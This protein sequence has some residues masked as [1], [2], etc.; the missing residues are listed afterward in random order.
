MSDGEQQE[1]VGFLMVPPSVSALRRRATYLIDLVV[2]GAM[3]VIGMV[4]VIG[5]LVQY[6]LLEADFYCLERQTRC[7]PLVII[8]IVSAVSAWVLYLSLIALMLACVVY[9]STPKL[10]VKRRRGALLALFA[11]N[12]Y[13]SVTLLCTVAS[14]GVG[15]LVD[16]R[17]R[18]GNSVSAVT[19]FIM[20]SLVATGLY[21]VV[22]V[23][24]NIYKQ[25]RRRW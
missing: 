20:S 24:Q 3:M 12:S 6:T 19:G 9:L 16:G 22:T 10:S 14:W 13:L 8:W 2:G 7:L 11:V 15:E 17:P 23:I 18:I 4:Q 21:I 1:D 25:Y 5:Y